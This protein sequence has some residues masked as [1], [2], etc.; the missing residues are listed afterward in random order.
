MLQGEFQKSLASDVRDM[1]EIQ[2][3]PNLLDS[4]TYTV[5]QCGRQMNTVFTMIYC[6]GM[7][8]RDDNDDSPDWQL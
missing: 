3:K 1:V 8:Q 5:C 2:D 6:T 7:L 4:E